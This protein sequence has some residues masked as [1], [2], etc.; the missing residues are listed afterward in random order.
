M[1]DLG[2]QTFLE[3]NLTHESWVSYIDAMWHPAQKVG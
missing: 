1:D 2:S 3:L